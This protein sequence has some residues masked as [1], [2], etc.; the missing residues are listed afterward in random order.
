[1]NLSE[2]GLDDEVKT[3]LKE[4]KDFI[5][6]RISQEGGNCDMFFGYHKIFER[7]IALKIYYGN[8]K[9]SS[10]YEPRILSTIEHD[11]ILKVR[12][13]KRIGDYYSYFM[14]DEISGGDLEK[15]YLSGILDLKEKLNII[16][17]ILNGL[18][19]LHREEISIVHRDI[20]PKNILIYDDSKQPLISDFGSVK[21]FDINLGC[22]NGSKTT[23]VYTPKEVFD[24]NKYTKQSDIYQVGVTM[25]QILGG[26]F[27]GAYVDWLNEKERHKL[28]AIIGHYEQSVFIDKVIHKLVTKN[29]LLKFDSLP[30][31]LD[32]N[33]IK[34]IQYAT[35]PKL[36]IRYSNTGSFMSELFKVQ[37][38]LTNWKVD[39][40]VYLAIKHTGE[41]FRVLES[42]KGFLT[43]K[44]GCGG[45]RRSG[46]FTNELE[47]HFRTIN[48]LKR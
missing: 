45:W 31:Y 19:E 36:N 30:K 29:S 13:A 4:Q 41:Q 23:L 9:S 42:K 7:R 44:F 46:N 12:D 16:H 22:V 2:L 5:I 17:G 3:F 27:P 25:F 10:H 37:K 1:M 39:G 33:I 48:N 20:K 34:V 35:N 26:Y 38:R 28:K 24:E 47:I 11:N 21:H 8:D 18:T 32:Q 15:C 14:T 6:D 40:D 43:E